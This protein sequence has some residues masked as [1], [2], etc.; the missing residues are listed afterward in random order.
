[1]RRADIAT[2]R[3]VSEKAARPWA[4]G[5]RRAF[6]IVCA[7]IGLA[8]FAPFFVL[9]ILLIRLEDGGPALFRQQRLG[10][11]RRPF[12]VLKFRTMREQRV[13]KLGRWLRATG[14]DETT[15]FLNVL[16]GDM[17]M[18]GPR[19]LTVEVVDR[20]GWTGDGQAF[21]FSVPPGITGLAQLLGGRSAR[22]SLH[23]DALY[24]RRG[25]LRLDVELILLSFAANILGKARV[26]RWLSD[27]RAVQRRR[28]RAGG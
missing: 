17:R 2:P 12:V 3:D 7:L 27:R 9:A 6:D 23:L 21:R 10:R 24:A 16:R 20:L 22:H 15:Q 26:R 8:V 13:T 1:M 18:V 11:F 5:P 14:L 28:R 4:D 25:S 19:P